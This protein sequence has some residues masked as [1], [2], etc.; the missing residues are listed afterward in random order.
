MIR[1]L[2]MQAGEERLS[3]F[4]CEAFEEFSRK[5]PEMASMF[6]DML[7]VCVNG[8]H[9]NPFTYKDAVSSMENMDGTKG[10]HWSMDDVR[11]VM[12]SKGISSDRFNEYDFAYALNMA[13]SDFKGSVSDSLDSYVRVALAFLND[14]DAKEGKAYSYWKKVVKGS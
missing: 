2:A 8:C 10:P 11:E 5:D 1:E 13:Y 3:S 7:Y 4:V 6:E 9:F 12:R 14:K